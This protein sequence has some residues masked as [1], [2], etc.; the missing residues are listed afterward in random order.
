MCTAAT[1]PAL[2]S[3]APAVGSRLKQVGHAGVNLSACAAFSL[4]VTAIGHGTY[5]KLVRRTAGLQDCLAACLLQTC[6]ALAGTAVAT[7]SAYF[8]P[9]PEYRMPVQLPVLVPCEDN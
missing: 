1:A 5:A 2:A 4:Y 9:E 8:L 7:C 3:L 6:S